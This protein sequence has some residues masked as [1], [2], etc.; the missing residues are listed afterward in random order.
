MGLKGDTE[1]MSVSSLMTLVLIEEVL[2][3]KESYT[4]CEDASL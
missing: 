4:A 1:V 2:A 3:V